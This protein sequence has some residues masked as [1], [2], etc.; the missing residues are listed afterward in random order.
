MTGNIHS[1]ETFGTLDG[2]GLRTVVFMQGCMNHCK[3]CH[4][5]D[6]VIREGGTPWQTADLIKE[7]TKNKSYWKEYLPKK[8][9]GGKIKGGVTFSGGDPFFQPEF[10]LEMCRLLKDEEVHVVVDTSINTDFSNVEKLAPYADLWMIS[11]KQMFDEVHKELIGG[12]NKTILENIKKLDQLI[13]EKKLSSK[14]RIRFVVIPGIT[15][16]EAHVNKLG[17]YIADIENLELV[18]LLPYTTIGKQK[19]LELFEKYWLEGVPEATSVD[20][21]KVQKI[22]SKYVSNFL[23]PKDA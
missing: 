2:P 8:K 20:V 4:N 5:P 11:I 15:D 1:I 7:I 23:I 14:I 19:W 6:S 12:S 17:E 22:L 3:F 10:L 16:T 13:S 21:D 18:E 9:R